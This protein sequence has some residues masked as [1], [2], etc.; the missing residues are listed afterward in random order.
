[1][2]DKLIEFK[3][4]HVGRR[5]LFL[6]ALLFAVVLPIIQQ[7]D[8]GLLAHALIGFLTGMLSDTLYTYLFYKEKEE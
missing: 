2:T 8:A 4:Q 3:K 5:F 6:I 7:F 1:M